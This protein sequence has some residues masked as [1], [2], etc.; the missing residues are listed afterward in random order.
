MGMHIRIQQLQATD[1]EQWEVLLRMKEDERSHPD[2]SEFISF[3][4]ARLTNMMEISIKERSCR[5]QAN[6]GVFCGVSFLYRA[7]QR[8]I[9]FL[10]GYAVD[11]GCRAI[12]FSNDS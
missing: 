11:K 7:K 12:A 1:E 4:A 10:R 6:R 5:G 8:I 2:V 3:R 9:E